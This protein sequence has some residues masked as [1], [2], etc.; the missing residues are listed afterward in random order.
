[1]QYQQ[2]SVWARND[3]YNPVISA[4]MPKSSDHGWQHVDYDGL[5][6]VGLLPSLAWISASLPK[7]RGFEPNLELLTQYSRFTNGARATCLS[8]P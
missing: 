5:K 1:M 8:S 2:F 6:S 4:G 7:R 3:K